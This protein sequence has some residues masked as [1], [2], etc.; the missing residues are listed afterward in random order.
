MFPHSAG[1]ELIHPIKFL[2]NLLTQVVTESSELE[3]G[4]GLEVLMDGSL[5]LVAHTRMPW[6]QIPDPVGLKQPPKEAKKAMI[7]K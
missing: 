4:L 5:R 2:L 3:R 7:R 1:N 6:Q